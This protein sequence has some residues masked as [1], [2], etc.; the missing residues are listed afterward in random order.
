MLKDIVA[1]LH[2]IGTRVSIFINPEIKYF[3]PA[4]LTGTDRV[5]LYTEPYAS[6]YHENREAAVKPYIEVANLAR[7]LGLGLNAGHDLDLHNLAFLKQS[8]P[9]LDEVSIGHALICDALYYGLENTIQMYRRKL[10]I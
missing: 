9:F 1:E 10:E 6:H 5:E 4:K 7:E 3:E 2:E 8:I